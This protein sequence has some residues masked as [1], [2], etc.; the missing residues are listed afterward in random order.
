MAKVAQTFSPGFAATL[1]LGK[2]ETHE[3]GLGDM[4]GSGLLGGSSGSISSGGWGAAGFSA[5]AFGQPRSSVV[6]AN[7]HHI[8]GLWW[9]ELM[10]N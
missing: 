1:T 10:G 7:F 3:G 4:G 2:E 6:A 5:G 9:E 8:V